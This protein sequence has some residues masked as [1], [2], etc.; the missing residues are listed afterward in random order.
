M[1]PVEWNAAMDLQPSWYRAL[2]ELLQ[3]NSGGRKQL[4]NGD[5][6]VNKLQFSFFFD[7]PP[8]KLYPA[9]PSTGAE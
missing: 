6:F 2:F 8:Y 7:F 1:E 3:A 4:G 5:E 9:A